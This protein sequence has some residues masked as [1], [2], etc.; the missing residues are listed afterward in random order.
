MGIR[1]LPR[2]EYKRKLKPL[3]SLCRDIATAQTYNEVL[4]LSLSEGALYKP[5]RGQKRTERRALVQVET[6][7]VLIER[8]YFSPIRPCSPSPT[9]HA[10]ISLT[11]K[12]KREL[13]LNIAWCFLYLFNCPWTDNS[14]SA[15]TISLLLST[16]ESSSSLEFE[17]PPYIHCDPKYELSEKSDNIG[18]IMND[19]VFLA[20]GQLLVEMELGRRITPTELNGHGQSSLWLTLNDVLREDGML[21][22]CDDY[23]KAIEGCLE[24]HRYIDELTPEE[25]AEESA[26]LIYDA[27]VVNLEK[28]FKHYRERI[29]KPKHNVSPS[30]TGLKLAASPLADAPVAQMA[31]SLKRKVGVEYEEGFGDTSAALSRDSD[32]SG[33]KRCPGI[34]PEINIVDADQRVEQTPKRP[35]V[36]SQHTTDTRTLVTR[37]SLHA[38]SKRST[39][40]SISQGFIQVYDDI[41][42]HTAVLDIR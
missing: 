40:S 24:L 34:Q 21:S 30:L 4:P 6:L 11:I 20:L 18:T 27:I 39:S 29:K 42:P 7:K 37:P 23:L 35:R 33:D 5:P 36:A 2:D 12:E 32:R 10:S 13:S 25:W 3:Q 31:K 17:T 38:D 22:A 8:Q 26:K 15:D 9:D 1:H 19:S 28:D 16:S 14:W 41:L